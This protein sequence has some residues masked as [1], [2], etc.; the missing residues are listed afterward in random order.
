M[1]HELH[2]RLS[3][4]IFYTARAFSEAIEAIPS[5]E[6]MER[7]RDAVLDLIKGNFDLS[8]DHEQRL[9][10]DRAASQA[11]NDRALA[12]TETAQ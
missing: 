10:A 12:A 6:H 11:A 1:N 8:M 3:E 9:R 7:Y 2:A 4:R 5:R